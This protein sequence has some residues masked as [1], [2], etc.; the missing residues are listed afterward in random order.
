MNAK[1]RTE[2]VKELVELR[3]MANELA[4]EITALED[5]IKADMQRQ[6]VDMLEAG[7]HTVRW[8]VVK[9]S[10]F[11]SCAFKT[12]YPTIYADYCKPK[13]MKRFTVL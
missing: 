13:E 10:R 8:S 3:E 7:K 4:E 6:G 9:S 12:A 2:K 1:K 5:E 11:D